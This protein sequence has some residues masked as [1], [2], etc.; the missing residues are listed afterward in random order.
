MAVVIYK[1]PTLLLRQMGQTGAWVE[2]RFQLPRDVR[3]AAAV[4]TFDILIEYMKV[5]PS[6]GCKQDSN[7]WTAWHL[8]ARSG[9]SEIIQVLQSTDP[10]CAMVKANDGRSPLGEM[11]KNC[12]SLPWL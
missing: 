12:C 8:A 3:R 6:W 9:H 4:G 10:G 7:G 2:I 11:Q 5:R 1:L